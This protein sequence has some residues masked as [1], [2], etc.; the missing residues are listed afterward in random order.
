MAKSVWVWWGGYQK[1]QT[2]HRVG[3]K[4]FGETG[5]YIRK[6]KRPGLPYNVYRR[7]L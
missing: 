3:K 6:T 2:A 7:Y 5:Y 1:L 4:L